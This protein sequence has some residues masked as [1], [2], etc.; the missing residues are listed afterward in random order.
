MESKAVRITVTGLVQGVGFRYFTMHEAVKLGL[1]GYASN[2]S[3]GQVEVVVSGERG[4]IE[5]LIKTM[6]V[7]P[8]HAYIDNVEIEEILL[9]EPFRSF[10]IR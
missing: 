4:M 3:T 6:R 5:E 2:L 10:Y 1:N 7:G 8:R 9:K